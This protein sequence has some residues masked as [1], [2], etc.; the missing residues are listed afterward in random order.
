MRGCLEK[1]RVPSF[2]FFGVRLLS[3]REKCGVA[4]LACFPRPTKE[5]PRAATPHFSSLGR[6][7]AFW[8]DM[9]LIPHELDWIT[10][11]EGAKLD[12]KGRL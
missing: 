6:E 1:F 9:D 11:F 8:K 2:E 7:S 5:Q 12:S 10:F 3:Q 4:A